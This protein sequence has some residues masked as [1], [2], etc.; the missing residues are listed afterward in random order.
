MV[1]TLVQNREF[2]AHPVSRSKGLGGSAENFFK[3]PAEMCV[4][5][6]VKL[7]GRSFARITLR[8]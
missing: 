2:E 4:G 6:E 7:R 3:L 8:D 5:G 1:G